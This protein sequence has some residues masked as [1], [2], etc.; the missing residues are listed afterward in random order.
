[1]SQTAHPATEPAEPTGRPA[2]YQRSFGGLVG[3]MIVLVV[4]LVA[5]VILRSLNRDDPEAHPEAVDYLG[6]VRLAQAA[7]LDVLYPPALPDGW[8]ATRVDSG[9]VWSISMLT[10]DGD[11]VGLKQVLRPGTSLDD[12]VETSVDEDATEGEAVGADSVL[13]PRWRTFTDSGGDTAY[14]A[15]VGGDWVL[16]FGS[17]PADELLDVAASIT[18]QPL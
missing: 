6:T 5:F 2:R 8:R 11:F 9:D 1:V 15:E 14:A 7:D 18:D 4:V 3:S 10:D 12:L 17:A 13:A 16:V